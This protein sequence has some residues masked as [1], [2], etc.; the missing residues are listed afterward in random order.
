MASA[1]VGDASLGHASHG[2]AE[3]PGA[4]T[5]TDLTQFILDLIIPAKREAALLFLSKH[6]ERFPKLA[7]LL[8]WS[9]GTMSALLQEI[10][11][12]YPALTPATLTAPASNRVCN[13]LAL[14]QCVASH[15]ETR[16]SF[17]KGERA[18]KPRPLAAGLQQAARPSQTMRSFRLSVFACPQPTWR[19]TCTRF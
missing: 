7:P 9:F 6:R 1:A 14:L 3:R 10:V 5:P 15:P 18:C 13:A 4:D 2:R 8:W 17:L 16:A 11:A 19:C 12:V